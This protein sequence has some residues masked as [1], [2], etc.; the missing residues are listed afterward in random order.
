MKDPGLTRPERV[1]LNRI[2]ADYQR[3]E[4]PNQ[5]RI[6]YDAHLLVSLALKLDEQIEK[7][8]RIRREA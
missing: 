4:L 2:T 6:R 3:D 5:E 8:M 1:F 7:M